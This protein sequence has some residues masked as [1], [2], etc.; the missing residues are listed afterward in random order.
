M[1]IDDELERI[2]LQKDFA[3]L[4]EEEKALVLQTIG[5]EE[6]YQTI[7]KIGLAVS[8]NSLRSTLEPRPEILL[9][10]QHRMK[11]EPAHYQWPKIFQ[12]KVPAYVAV[13][14]IV[15]T[16][17]LIFIVRSFM[18]AEHLP[19][20]KVTEPV[21]RIDTVF[22]TR[23]DTIVRERI[24]Y[25]QLNLVSL[26]KK[27]NPEVLVHAKQNPRSGVSMKDKEEL[28]KLLVSGSD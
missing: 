7:R 25:R 18:P 21:V 23:I 16:S 26:P 15:I 12:I 3:A 4:T 13:L 10:L 22:L 6:E 11:S 8:D 14:G 19:L 5:S 20:G 9:A 1:K 28:N 17:L 2:I 27:L 24:V